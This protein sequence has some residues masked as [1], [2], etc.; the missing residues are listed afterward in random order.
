MQLRHISLA[1]MVTVLL[2]M[3]AFST[4]AQKPL[5]LV[6]LNTN[7]EREQLPEAEVA[8]LQKGHLNNISRLYD[9]GDLLLAGPFEGS[10]GIFV[11]TAASLQE[12][13]SLLE[14]DPAISAGR[15]NIEV[16]PMKVLTGMICMQDDI[17]EMI[18]MNFVHFIKKNDTPSNKTAKLFRKYAREEAIFSF[19]YGMNED[20]QSF[21]AI[22]SS[23][24]D[25]DLFAQKSPL[26]RT[27]GFQYEVKSWW[28][29]N[30]TFCTD[31]KR[32]IN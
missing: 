28:T 31:K 27:G 5:Y 11:L 18:G 21:V 7:P 17:Y 8:E 2:L 29:T 4:S 23:D 15:F 10:G 26:L 24:Q 30:E 14:T 12:A 13:G 22:I 1:G 19:S 3:I 25:P 32:K 16:Y 6:F 9:N 20:A